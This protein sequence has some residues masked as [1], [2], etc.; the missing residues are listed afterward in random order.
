[1]LARNPR[2][3]CA[4]TALTEVWADRSVPL[5]TV[6]PCRTAPSAPGIDGHHRSV[7]ISQRAAP[8]ST[9]LVFDVQRYS[10]HDGPGIRTT[11]F[12]KGCPL[13]CTWCHNPE[14][15]N[16]S[17]E[18]RVFGSR[19]IGCEACR[20]VCPLG[21][22]RPGELPD[23]RTC[24]ACGSCAGV[25]PTRAREVIGRTTTVEAL[26]ETLAADRL[27]YD[28]SGGGVTFSGGE[29]LRQWQ[30]LIRCL[31]AAKTRGYHVA[32]DTSGFAS[33]R[34]ILRVA[35]A[36][37]LFL[38]DLK[39][40]DPVRHRRFT[41]VDLA[42]ILRNLRALDE[43]GATVWIRVPLVPGHNDDTENIEA[44]G[45]F[46]AGLRRTRRVHVLPY[47]RLASA[48]YERL[49]LLNPMVVIQSPAAADIDRAVAILAAHGLDVHV[50]G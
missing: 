31:E 15:M 32:V 37:D 39:V 35:E 30:F 2:S 50:G 29:P 6:D 21:E 49:G 9:G 23:P 26:L 33:E 44:V 19:C 47:H 14:S 17:P 45:R 20:E 8:G 4:I 38:F 5:G 7:V 27:F 41:G 28:E 1:M 48:K 43:R 18:L 42:P 34:T 12:L 40:M 24:L 11:V 36:A 46:V 16:A 3:R 13:R 25:C 10:L 22:A